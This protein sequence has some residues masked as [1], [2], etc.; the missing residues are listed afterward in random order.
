[1]WRHGYQGSSL[2]MNIRIQQIGLTSGCIHPFRCLAQYGLHPAP[3]P[4]FPLLEWGVPR[5]PYCGLSSCYVVAPICHLLE[6]NRWVAANWPFN[7]HFNYPDRPW[8]IPYPSP[9]NEPLY[10]VS[11]PSV[12]LSSPG[13]STPVS[14]TTIARLVCNWSPIPTR[15]QS[16]VCP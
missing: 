16:E 4:Q 13:A 9:Q 1:M 2:Q 14:A 10:Q 15:I 3:Q 11:E 5:G 6:S 12:S 7:T 8:P